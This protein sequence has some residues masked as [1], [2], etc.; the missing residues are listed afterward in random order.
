MCLRKVKY[1][2]HQEYYSNTW[3]SHRA[4]VIQQTVQSSFLLMLVKNAGRQHQRKRNRLK[5]NWNWQNAK[6]G[7]IYKLKKPKNAYCLI[8]NFWKSRPLKYKMSNLVIVLLHPQQTNIFSISYF[9]HIKVK[10]LKIRKESHYLTKVNKYTLSKN[11]LNK[12]SK[13]FGVSC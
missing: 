10:F 13:S 5:F 6:L 3:T 4:H 2:T 1:W 8:F 11:T 12:T 9:S 7:N